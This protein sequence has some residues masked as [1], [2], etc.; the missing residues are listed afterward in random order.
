MSRSARRIVRFRSSA[1]LMLSRKER[2]WPPLTDVP[3]CNDA[4]PSTALSST[5]RAGTRPWLAIRRIMRSGYGGWRGRWRHRCDRR[6]RRRHPETEARGWRIEDNYCKSLPIHPRSSRLD[7]RSATPPSYAEGADV[8]REK[9]AFPL[10]TP[11][12]RRHNRSRQTT[13]SEH[14][15]RSQVQP[16]TSEDVS[17][18]NHEQ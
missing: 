5:M 8:T 18:A 14:L 12:K 2:R 10:D 16:C 4:T 17:E 11:L 13:A 3:A 1:I 9:S 7:L 6:C 15:H